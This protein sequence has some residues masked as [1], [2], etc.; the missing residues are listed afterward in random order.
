LEHLSNLLL[1]RFLT[2][3]LFPLKYII[4]KGDVVIIQTYSNFIYCENTKY[5]YEYLSVETNFEVYWHTDNLEIQ[6]YLDSKGFKYIT[7]KR[8]FHLIYITL[9]AKCVIDSG[10]GYFDI[11]NLITNNV[12]KIT[13]MHGNGPKATVNIN[14]LNNFNEAK[15]KLTKFDYVNFPSEYSKNKIGKDLCQLH[16]DSLVNL[17]YPRCDQFFDKSAIK[18][19]Y[20]NKKSTK[21]LC[22]SYKSG[23][24]IILYT[25]TWRQYEYTF[26]LLELKSF[27]W[28]VF[29]E[30]LLKEN[31]YFFFTIHTAKLLSNFHSPD[32]KR[33]KYIDHCEYPFYDV[34]EFMME[35]DILINDYS[36]TSTDYSLLSR[37]QI[38]FMPDYEKFEKVNGFV[39]NY[40]DVMPG[41]EIFT[42]AELLEVIDYSLKEPD[43]YVQKYKQ[44][45]ELLLKHYNEMESGNSCKDFSDFIS[46]NIETN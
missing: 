28:L 45:M 39:E 31:I 15:Y 1:K 44:K 4:S 38:F 3:I 20:I 14:D 37:P 17:G 40:R 26:P 21:Y 16:S 5:L 29:D 25:P 33:I 22:S 43:K 6:R 9:R 2:L 34:N 24:K 13:T 10:T 42:F 8:I 11:F 30:Y 18:E 36:T 27:N 35:V 12:I 19:R 23:G 41:R 46:Q 7:R 32:L